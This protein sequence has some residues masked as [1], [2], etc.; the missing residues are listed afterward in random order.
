MGEE[1]GM[2]DEAPLMADGQYVEEEQEENDMD[3]E[4]RIRKINGWEAYAKRLA[5]RRG[6]LDTNEDILMLAW[7]EYLHALAAYTDAMLH[8]QQF[9]YDEALDFLTQTHGMEK[10]QAESM[11]R[12]IAAKPG[13]AVSY[14]IGLEALENAYRKYSKK[15][16][17]K[18]NEADFHAKLFRIGNI[19]PSLLDKELARLYKQDKKK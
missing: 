3:A 18:F 12:D 15:F 9:S 11:I 8:T 6:Y 2:I 1:F 7:D 13:E 14:L 10:A 5:Q 17:K 16:G 4:M 19:P